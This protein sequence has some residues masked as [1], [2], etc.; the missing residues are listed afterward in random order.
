MIK[1]LW[2][3]LPVNDVAK[4]R[5]FFTSIGFRLNQNYGNSDQ[6]ASLLIGANDLVMMLWP[7]EQ[8]KSFTRHEISSTAQGNEVL[9]S[10]DAES[11]D[12]VDEICR[13]VEA[14]GGDVFAKPGWNQ[15]WMYGCAFTDLDGHRWN[16]LHMDFSKMP[17]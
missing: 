7:A 11:A 2:L 13:K 5:D 1:S 10:F 8:F 12:E 16:I 4:S 14:A 6:S 15:G 17:K 3:N 9:F